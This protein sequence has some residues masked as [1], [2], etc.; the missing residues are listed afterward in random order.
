MLFLSTSRRARLALPLLAAVGLAAGL[1][2]C[3]SADDDDDDT[4]RTFT[5]TVANVSTPGTI[6]TPRAMG[7][8]PFSPPVYS[9]FDGTD[10]M[11]AVGDRAN[12]GTE[13]IAE[14]G[15]GDEMLALLERSENV[16]SHGEEFSP[17]GPDNGPALFAG[18]SV[19]FTVSAVPGQRFQFESMFVQ[20]NDWFVAFR[21]G[22][23]ELFDGSTPIA[24][25]DVT[26]RLGIYDAG[27]EAD[28]APGTGPN[29]KPAQEGTATNVGPADS[30]PN[31]RS[32]SESGFAIPA[33]NRV[34]RVTV[35]PS[36]N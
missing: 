35:Q 33:L 31:V 23:L 36:S 14:D 19:T 34:I 25:G 16:T 4:P 20:S 13:R 17:G 24:G 10:P 22:G 9:V 21:G 26:G 15:F 30:N 2:G 8:V 7:T 18:E 32:A 11:F 1:A 6:D 28:T 27:T 12:L 5:V 29:Q 3:D